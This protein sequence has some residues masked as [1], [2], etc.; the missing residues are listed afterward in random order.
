[1]IKDL[2][3]GNPIKV[4]LGFAVPMLFGN[5]FQQMY[6]MADSIIVG[7][8][9]G[10]NAL[11]AVGGTGALNFLVL[12]FII[13]VSSGFM[14]PVSQ[15]FGAKDFEKLRKYVTNAAWLSL[16]VGFIIT[17]ITVSLTSTLL[18]ITNTP[19]DIFQGSYEYIATIFAGILGIM[20]Y[21]LFSGIMR[22]LGDSK[23]PLYFLI[24]SSFVNIVLDLL[25]VIVFKMGVFG[26]AFATDISQLISCVLCFLFIKKRYTILK[27]RKE[28]WSFNPLLAKKLMIMGIPMGLQYSITAIGSTVMQAAVNGLGSVYVAAIT[29]G[30]KVSL[31]FTQAYDTLGTAMATFCGQNLGARKIN[32]IHKGMKQGI[33]AMGIYTIIAFCGIV[34]GGRYVALLF[35]NAGETVL[36]GYV[37]KYLF[38]NAAFY[39]PLGLLIMLRYAIQGLGHSIFAM[40]AGIMEMVARCAVAFLGLRWFGVD[41]IYYSNAAAWIAANIFLI[42]AF[43]MVMKKIEKNFIK[44]NG[45]AN[46]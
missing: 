23:T 33:A 13:G 35:V 3:K 22:A 5:L 8:Y 45:N 26:A 41:A 31:L 30:N 16:I 2:T 46:E 1:M 25:F 19:D 9:I 14:I 34:F 21:N 15:A 40:T 37:S 20:F 32:R 28:D 44:Q 12:G 29:A 39:F 43:I 36:L 42:P 6:N 18:K 4:I 27:M 17:V 24:F 11:A 7:K 38:A 10:V